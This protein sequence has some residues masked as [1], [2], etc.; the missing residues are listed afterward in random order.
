[1]R[2]DRDVVHIVGDGTFYFCNPSSLY[3][4]SKQYGLPIFTVVLD[5]G[6]WAAVK[7]ATLRMY[8]EGEARR[9]D[10]FCS[11]LAADMDF[12]RVAE[13]AGAHGELLVDPADTD[14]AIARCLNALRGGRSALLHARVAPH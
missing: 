14:A 10:D 11:R 9:H 2:P 5:N 12:A 3:A 8:P 6:G 1:A 7:D 4:V 13:A